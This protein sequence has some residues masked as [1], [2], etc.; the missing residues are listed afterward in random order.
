M[1]F[2]ARLGFVTLSLLAVHCA[3]GEDKKKESGPNVV[4]NK[5]GELVITEPARAAFIENAADAPIAAVTVRGKGASKDL[6]INGSEVDVASDGTFT[7]S[8][9]PSIGLNL[10]VATDGESRLETP[11]LFG[12]FASAKDAVR[13][14]IAIEVGNVGIEAPLP[15]A[16]LT[17]VTNLALEGRDLIAMLRGKAFSGEMSGATWSF[18]VT[19]GRHDKPTVKLNAGNKG[20]GITVLAS[21]IAVDGDLRIVFGSID[22]KAPVR[23]SVDKAT[24]LGES[25]IAVDGSTGTLGVQMPSSEAFLDGFAYQSN[26]AGFPCCVDAIV[27]GI[28]RAKVEDGIKSGIRDQL[29][30]A[31][32]LTLD[33]VGLPKEIDLSS[34]GFPI[35]VGI[36]SKLD[37]G[38]FDDRGGLL[39][40]SV[41]FD[42]HFGP[43]ALGTKAPGWLTVGRKPY[44][45]SSA[46]RAQGF[47]ASISLDA[48]NQALFAAWGNGGLTYTA[49]EPLKAKLTPALPPVIAITEEGTLRIGVGE[50]Q[51]QRPDSPAPF[52]AAS[53]LQDLKAKM[54]G[55]SIIL[56][57][58]GEPTISVTY[59]ADGTVGSGLNLVANAAKDQLQKFLKPFKIPVPKFSLEKLGPGFA[60]QSLAVK[61]GS[62][63]IDRATG[64]IGINGAFTIAK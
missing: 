34:T 24:I 45:T 25:S 10:I 60:G 17:S 22:Y 49:P 20:I 9:T 36:T 18:A 52:A 37:A 33:S 5:P 11:F 32:Q 1:R 42:G 43:D 56:E 16:S 61:S 39:T 31:L 27:S 62:L 63:S 48:V 2:F 26:N 59:I 64:R 3:S 55:D 4:E 40:A 28:L 51:I 6:K 23:I 53:V 29:P 14:A 41:L 12:H 58:Q 50:V 15:A 19:G 7:A 47:G 13:Q 30:S 54:D 46:A 38:T 57:P 21:K 35:K 8:I 44:D